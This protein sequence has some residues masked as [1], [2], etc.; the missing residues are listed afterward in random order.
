MKGNKYEVGDK[1]YRIT[2]EVKTVDNKEIAMIKFEELIVVD[3]SDGISYIENLTIGGIKT[4][5]IVHSKSVAK[6][7]IEELKETMLELWPDKRLEIEKL[8]FIEDIKAYI[9]ELRKMYYTKNN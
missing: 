6:Y 4:H 7:T 2:N 3:I 9:E 5:G 1:L 8:N